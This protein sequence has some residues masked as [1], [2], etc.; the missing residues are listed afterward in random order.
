MSSQVDLHIH[1]TASDGTDTPLQLAEKAIAAGIRVFALTD[2]DTIIGVEQMA[3]HRPE[4]VTFISGIEFSCCMASGKCHILGY[5]C[6]M[7]HPAFQ[8]ALAQG[9]ALR[10][11]KLERRIDFLREKGMCFPEDEL[12]RLRQIP[13]VG[14]PHIGNLMVKYSYA[15]SRNEAIQN[16]INLCPT[17]SSRIQAETAVKAILTSG[18][19][20]VWAHPLGGEGEKTVSP[21]QF[22]MMLDELLGCGIIGMECWYSKYS[23]AR[24]VQLTEIARK[25]GLLVSGGSDYH[26]TNKAI[27]LG[28]LNKD[29]YI[30][31]VGQLTIL[32]MILGSRIQSGE[33]N[34]RR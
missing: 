4:G 11:A 22:D 15:T 26:G 7:A 20:P 28:A 1:S 9:A 33:V 3:E 18:G 29:D 12:D 19:I 24:C 27:A 5:R 14:K 13:G 6:N 16:T 17:G 25:R 31:P 34:W 23:A 10:K 30:V 2:H 32:D 8:D 21:K